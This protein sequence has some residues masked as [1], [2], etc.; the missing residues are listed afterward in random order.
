MTLFQIHNYNSTPI[1]S[2]FGEDYAKRAL[3]D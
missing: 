3:S 1:I 2:T